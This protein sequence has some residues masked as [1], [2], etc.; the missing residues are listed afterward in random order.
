MKSIDETSPFRVAIITSININNH[1]QHTILQSIITSQLF[2]TLK[3]GHRQA[4][5]Q[6]HDV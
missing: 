1:T 5:I 6:E 4:M 3:F 2:S